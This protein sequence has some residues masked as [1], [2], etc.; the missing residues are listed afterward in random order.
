MRCSSLRTSAVV[1]VGGVPM[2]GEAGRFDWW[3]AVRLEAGG[4]CHRGRVRRPRFSDPMREK[5][6][7]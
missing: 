3:Q 4:G 1:V 2:E 5:F 7:R 6:G